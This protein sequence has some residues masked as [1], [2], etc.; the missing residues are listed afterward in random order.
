MARAVGADETAEASGLWAAAEVDPT[1]DHPAA[2][3]LQLRRSGTLAGQITL[4][5]LAGTTPLDVTNAAIT[6]E[7]TDG[8]AKAALLNGVP[9]V[10]AT[11]TGHFILPD[12]PPG[13]YRLT[14]DLG[15]PWMVDRVTADGHDGLDQPITVAPGGYMND[16]TIAATDVPSLVE[17]QALNRRDGRRAAFALVFAFGVDPANRQGR[18]TQAVRANGLGRFTVTGLPS[19][20]YLV[21]IAAGADPAVWYTPEFFAQLTASATLVPVSAG[22]TRMAVVG[23]RPK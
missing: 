7:P 3:R 1:D 16:L 9:R 20:D 10:Y 6:L 12:V 15:P 2:V 4:M 23:G 8:E 21:G 18:R 5:P 11:G 14:A 17:G 19:G 13:H 22:T